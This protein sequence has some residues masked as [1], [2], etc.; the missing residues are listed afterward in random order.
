M[1]D[2][3]AHQDWNQVVFRKRPAAAA[4]ADAAA[5]RA[6][7]RAG[8]TESVART[9]S[10]RE[11]SDRARKLEAAIDGDG[12]A[13]IPLNVLPLAAR[14]ELLRARTGRGMSQQELARSMNLPTSIV[15]DI[16]AGKPIQDHTVLAKINRVLGTKVRWG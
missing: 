16:E 5:L 12:R 11:A 3:Y 13:K 4:T 9:G 8:A 1:S 15:A 7:Q 10:G 6:A 14:Q 2:G